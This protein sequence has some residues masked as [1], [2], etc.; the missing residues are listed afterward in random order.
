[1]GLTFSQQ[2]DSILRTPVQ[3]SDRKKIRVSEDD[4]INRAEYYIE[5]DDDIADRHWLE[6]AL[7][8]IQRIDAIAG[9]AVGTAS[10]MLE[11]FDADSAWAT[12]QPE[13]A[14]LLQHRARLVFSLSQAGDYARRAQSFT[15]R[16]REAVR[17]G[18]ITRGNADR[19]LPKFVWHADD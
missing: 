5:S 4:G 8:W 2:I 14:E 9:N 15:G 3:V 11:R 7:E 13:L 10:I 6:D 18:T 12:T 19:T 17:L 1:M 16:M